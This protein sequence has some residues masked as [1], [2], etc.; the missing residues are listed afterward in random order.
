MTPIPVTIVTGAGEE[1]LAQ[2]A[3]A[4]SRVAVVLHDPRAA[5]EA[6][7]MIGC[8]C[9]RVQGSLAIT[10]L[11]MLRGVARGEIAAFDHALV[12]APAGDAAQVLLELVGS[13]ALGAAYRVSSLVTLGEGDDV[14]IADHVFAERLPADGHWLVPRPVAPAHERPAAIRARSDDALEAFSLGWDSP[15]TLDALCNWL[16]ALASANGER[17]LRVRGHANTDRGTFALGGVRHVVAAPAAIPQAT[18][19]S[20]LAFFTR[21]L[22]PNDLLPPWPA[23]AGRESPCTRA[24]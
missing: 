3:T 22:E 13:P 12:C 5:S 6:T 14:A 21:G 10:L 7:P 20:R 18:G 9:C 4:L 23:R 19:D 15:T 16:H 8:A 1:G 2:A 11:S 17:L 24:S